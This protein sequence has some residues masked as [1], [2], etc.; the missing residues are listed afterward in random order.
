MSL[1]SASVSPAAATATAAAAAAATASTPLPIPGRCRCWCRGP[2]S[3]FE[4]ASS[5]LP[6]QSVEPLLTSVECLLPHSFAHDWAQFLLPVTIC[7][8]FN[9]VCRDFTA[10]C[11]FDSHTESQAARDT[12]PLSLWHSW[13]VKLA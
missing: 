11:A 7:P 2:V 5:W 4:T 6:R 3:V 9:C 8:F 12:L 13:E 10:R 1:V